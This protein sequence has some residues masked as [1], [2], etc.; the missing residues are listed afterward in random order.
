M[1][2]LKE[3]KT[4]IASVSS[5][6]K[7]TSAIKLV[8]S[9]KLRKVQTATVSLNRYME[10]LSNILGSLIA[11]KQIS[12]PL[13]QAHDK[14]SKVTIIVISSNSSLCGSYNGNVIKALNKTITEYQSKGVSQI[15][16]IPIGE[17]VARAS[18]KISGVSRVMTYRHSAEKCTYG[19]LAELA[20]SLMDAFAK[21]ETDEVKIV[22]T[23]F[24][25]MSSQ[26][27]QSSVFLPFDTNNIKGGATLDED[28]ILEPSAVEIIEHLLPYTMST[29]LYDSFLSSN[30]S[31]H[32]AR[33]IAMQTATDN[34]K[35]IL[36]ELRLTYNKQRQTA[37]TE[38][39]TDISNGAQK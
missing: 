35:E 12:M 33:M 25:S 36:E 22:Y 38:E 10:S 13:T 19:E 37:I 4:R 11:G 14:I 26:S 32:S 17:K 18:E 2:S 34:A 23:R 21:G 6:L 24:K 1:A 20:R 28:Y 30:A 15:E 29:M 27:V 8:A 9:S 7:I 16:I 39:L 31:E 3:I 5:T